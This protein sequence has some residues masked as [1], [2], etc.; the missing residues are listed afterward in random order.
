[1][2]ESTEGFKKLEESGFGDS[3]KIGEGNF[4]VVYKVS[5]TT[6]ILRNSPIKNKNDKDYCDIIC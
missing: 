6:K 1:M 3:K 4:G 2:K 5:T